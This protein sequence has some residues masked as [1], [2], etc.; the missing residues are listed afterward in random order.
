VKIKSILIKNFRSIHEQL[1]ELGDYTCLVGG[2]GS[3]KS[4]V[5]H[6]LNVFFGEQDI[7]GLDTR[8]LSEEDFHKKNTGE[9]IEITVTFADLSTEAVQELAHYV[10]QDQLVVSVEARFE[11]ETGRAEVKQYGRRMVIKDFAPFFEAE[12]GGKKVADL[13]S[14]YGVLQSTYPDLPPPGTKDAMIAALRAYEEAHSEKC[15]EVPSSDEFYGVAKGRNHLEK[16]IQ[17]VHVPAVKEASSEQT[18]ARATALGKL[19]ARSV[20]SKIDFQGP[21]NA[22]RKEMQEKYGKLLADSQ[23]QLREVSTAL[24]N[25]LTAWAHEDATLRLVWH[26]DPERAI[27]VD[28]PFAKAILGEAGFEGELARFGHG[29]QRSFILALLQELSGSDTSAGPCLILACEEPEL[30]QH[31][32]QARH[33]NNLLVRLSERNSQVLIATH[34]PY[35]VSGEGFESVRMV[36]KSKGI[37]SIARTTHDEVSARIAAARGEVPTRASGQLAKIHQALQPALSEMFFAARI[38][39]VEGLEDSAYLTTY[40]HLLGLWDDYRR[41]GCHIIPTDKKSAML[42]PLAV[43]ASLGIPAF[44][45]FD[46][47]GEKPDKNGSRE[48]HRKDNTAILKLCGVEAPD[49]FPSTTFWGSGVIMWPSEIGEVIEGEIG[50]VEWSRCQSEADAKYGYAGNLHKNILH[51]ACSLETAWQAEKRSVSLQNACENIMK[52]AEANG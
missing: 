40:L 42:Q 50:K 37:T 13:K 20:R 22:I 29:L 33:L 18:E 41:L 7:P 1:V 38:V 30:F 23:D 43:A 28:D 3:G 49:P 4:N 16:F 10:R 25:R 8:M 51:I 17:W 21:I 47:D 48:K 27:R 5:I 26:Q 46:S 35:F 44:A 36:R 11:P 14:M 34:S 24:K 15:E 12:K 45:I 6:A 2:N 9:P 52:F 32:P 39:F 19:L 31:P